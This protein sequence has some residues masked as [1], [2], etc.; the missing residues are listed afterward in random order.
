MDRKHLGFVFNS[1]KTRGVV[2]DAG[3]HFAA[4]AHGTFTRPKT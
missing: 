4:Q 1:G 3:A 2:R